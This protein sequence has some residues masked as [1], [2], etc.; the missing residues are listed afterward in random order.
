MGNNV[1]KNPLLAQCEAKWSDSL[2]HLEES[3]KLKMKLGTNNAKAKEHY[4]LS[5]K[6]AREAMD[7]MKAMGKCYV[8]K[9]E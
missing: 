8:V 4:D 5:Q 2:K 9:R 6:C 3:E 7:I 1:E